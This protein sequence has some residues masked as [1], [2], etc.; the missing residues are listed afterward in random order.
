MV[1]VLPRPVEVGERHRAVVVE[2]QVAQHLSDVAV[3]PVAQFVTGVAHRHRLGIRTALPG[4]R[5][6]QIH[7]V[8]HQ[9]GAGVGGQRGVEAAAECPTSTSPGSHQRDD[10]VPRLASVDS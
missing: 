5:G 9:I 2:V 1:E 6:G 3:E 7:D 10:R 4:Q 8:A